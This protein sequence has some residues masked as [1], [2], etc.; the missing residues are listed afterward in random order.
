MLKNDMT[1]FLM[2]FVG[3]FA[4]YGLV[5]MIIFPHRA[6]EVTLDQVPQFNS[7][8]GS[9][10]AMRKLAFLGNEFDI[11]FKVDDGGLVHFP[12]EDAHGVADG[13]KS[14]D[15]AIFIIVYFVSTLICLI[16]L[17]NLLIA[18]MGSDSPDP[19]PLATPTPGKKRVS[20]GAAPSDDAAEQDHPDHRAAAPDRKPLASPDSKPTPAKKKVAVSSVDRTDYAA[21]GD[22]LG[23]STT[24]TLE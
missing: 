10:Q 11:Q 13:W 21:Q 22:H 12:I 16:L 19:S 4:N 18:M 5:L 24:S 17:L 15:F 2:L 8:Y 9:I 1:T 3:L 20:F 6:D 23:G 7:I 14:V